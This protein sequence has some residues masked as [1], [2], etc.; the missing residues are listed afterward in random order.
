MIHRIL[1]AMKVTAIIPD[2]L[3]KEAKNLTNSK[4]ITEAL[5]IAL[6]E[7]INIKHIKELNNLI[8]TSPLEFNDNFDWEKIR[9]INRIL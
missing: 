2:E 1:Y 7:W 9:E 8:E 5:K 6:R 3:I 4:N